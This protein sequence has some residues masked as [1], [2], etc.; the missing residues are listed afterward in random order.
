LK[1]GIIE[2]PRP[3]PSAPDL[4]AALR[5][6]GVRIALASSA[7]REEV[8]KYLKLLDGEKVADEIITGAAGQATKPAPD[9]FARALGSPERVLVIGDTVYDIQAAKKVGLP[10]MAVL[11]GGIERRRLEDAGAR[12]IYA[13]AGTITADLARVLELG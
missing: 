7:K 2:H 1:S 12:G 5:K 10:C 13:D 3:L 8:E 9:I 4:H 11:T 6:S